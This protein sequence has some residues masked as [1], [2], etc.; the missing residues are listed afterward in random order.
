MNIFQTVRDAVSARE[1]GQRYGLVFASNSRRARAFCPFHD[2]GRHPA[3]GFCG[4]SDNDKFCH[5][6][7]CNVTVDCVDLAARL[8]NCSKFEAA[9]TIA[10][11]FNVSI[12]LKDYSWRKP[13]IKHQHMPMQERKRR[14]YLVK[15]CDTGNQKLKTL[16]DDSPKRVEII[17]TVAVA[18]KELSN[19]Y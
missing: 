14:E 3:L 6:F 10:Q 13:Y 19:I 15:V 2:D 17:D 16:P 7:A 18:M 12:D 5:C 8:L 1:V 4:G 9:K 11:D